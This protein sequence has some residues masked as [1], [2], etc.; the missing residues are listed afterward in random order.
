MRAIRG[1]LTDNMRL[2]EN[3]WW[4]PIFNLSTSKYEKSKLNNCLLCF[5]GDPF[6]LQCKVVYGQQTSSINDLITIFNSRYFSWYYWQSNLIALK[7]KF[8]TFSRSSLSS[9]PII[10]IYFFIG[11]TK[12]FF[13]SYFKNSL[14]RKAPVLIRF[15][16]SFMKEKFPNWNFKHCLSRL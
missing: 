12:N 8:Q 13:T 2:A 16:F 6:G 7:N 15:F 11:N 4:S 1:S 10:C 14:I 5:N 3:Y 9:L